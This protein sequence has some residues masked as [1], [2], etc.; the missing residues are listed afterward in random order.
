[1]AVYLGMKSHYF[2]LSTP[3]Q[4]L[5]KL[6]ILK[7]LKKPFFDFNDKIFPLLQRGQK[8]LLV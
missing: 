6:V 5:V 8:K 3:F 4:K 7:I 2:L 1:M